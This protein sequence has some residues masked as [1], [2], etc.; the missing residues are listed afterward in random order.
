VAYPVAVGV[1]AADHVIPLAPALSAYVHAWAASLVSAAVRLIPLG[2]TDG[3]RAMMQ[4]E[5]AV[6][7]TIVAGMAG[8]LTRLSSVAILSDIAAMKHET[9]HTRLFRS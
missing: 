6:A 4:L 1:T 8:D 5:P 9:Q 7:Q 3:Q 2:H